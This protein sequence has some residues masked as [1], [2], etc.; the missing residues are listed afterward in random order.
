MANRNQQAKVTP[1]GIQRDLRLFKESMRLTK[2]YFTGIAGIGFFLTCAGIWADEATPQ[3]VASPVSQ[4]TASA[5]SQKQ[6][7]SFRLEPFPNAAIQSPYGL[8]VGGGIKL[9]ETK[10][11]S[12]LS[13]SALTSFSDYTVYQT[14]FMWNRPDEWFFRFSGTF[15][16]NIQD[17]YGEGDNT[18]NVFQQLN[19]T[20]D[21]VHLTFQ[22]QLAHGWTFG[23]A[24]EYLFR[25]WTNTTLFPNESEWKIGVQT[26]FDDRA[27]LQQP[28]HGHYLRFGAY[29]LPSNGNDGF[30]PEVWQFEGD[31]RLYQKILEPVV[32]VSRF[33]ADWTEGNPS[34][35]FR[36]SLGGEWELRGYDTNR[37][38]GN[39]FWILQEEAR[40]PL[41]SI[42]EGVLSVDAGD[43]ADTSFNALLASFQVGLRTMPLPYFGV[44]VRLDWGF[45][46]DQNEIWLDVGEP[47]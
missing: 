21:Q 20:L 13:A 3:T 33:C 31:A 12:F 6:L 14:G 37:F 36:Y 46:S 24:F 4:A 25:T 16:D 39:R 2:V 18:P 38:R 32:L 7:E 42:V 5:D 30:S 29:T 19:S 1:G 10:T 15:G 45:G 43:I 28:N 23:P 41:C 40:F 47:F 22:T 44:V 27:P 8:V 11:E 34:Y 17:Y 9:L 35:S 26:T